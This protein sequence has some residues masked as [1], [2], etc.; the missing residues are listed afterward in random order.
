M[1][2]LSIWTV[3]YL[4]AFAAVTCIV[5]VGLLF[6]FWSTAGKIIDRRRDAKASQR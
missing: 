6:L 2:G 4:W 3:Y 1:I 5:V